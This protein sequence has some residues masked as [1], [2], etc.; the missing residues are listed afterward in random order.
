[1]AEAQ[2]QRKPLKRPVL[3]SSSLSTW[4]RRLLDDVTKFKKAVIG[5]CHCH[6]FHVESVCSW[7]GASGRRLRPGWFAAAQDGNMQEELF[8]EHTES[9]LRKALNAGGRCLDSWVT[10][11]M[12]QY[13]TDGNSY[14]SLPA[15]KIPQKFTSV[16]KAGCS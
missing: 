12:I 10:T 14:S 2:K 11:Y 1:M 3:A 6:V 13:S 4:V 7:A 16:K 5:T 9:L 8:N 15:S